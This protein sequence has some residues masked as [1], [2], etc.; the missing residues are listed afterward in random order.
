MDESTYLRLADEAFHN[1]ADA[2][3]DVDPEAID[4]E[5][6]G[7][8]VTLSLP[9]GKRYVVNTQRPTR[10]IWLAAASRAWHFSYDEG[11]SRWMDDKG[12]GEDLYT[13]LAKVVHDGSGVDVTFS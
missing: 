3:E 8:V 13:V 4:C 7:D 6:A 9:G 10:Q 12:S 11:S 2:F 5:V 1:I